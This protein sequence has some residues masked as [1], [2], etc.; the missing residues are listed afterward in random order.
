MIS[1]SG[2]KN[3]RIEFSGLRHGEK[4]Y[5]ELLNVAEHTKPTHHEKIMIVKEVTD[6]YDSLN[7]EIGE[8]LSITAGFASQDIVMKM[9]TIVPEFLSMNSSYEKL[10][11]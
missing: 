1:L 4:L 6:E 11:N 9:K 5:E 8:L 2:L 7:R 10:D 3:I